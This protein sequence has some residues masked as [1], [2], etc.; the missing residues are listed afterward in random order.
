MSL[1]PDI[2]SFAH[3]LAD[4]AGAIARR[5][6][7]QPYMVDYKSDKSPVTLADHEIETALRE[8][9][10]DRF[11]DAYGILGEESGASHL[12]AEYVWVIDPIDGTRAFIAGKPTFTTLIALCKNGVP[13]LGLID[14]PI[15][16][17][18]WV[19]VQGFPSTRNGQPVTTRPCDDL[20]LAL[21]STTSPE[22]FSAIASPSFHAVRAAARDILYGC[23]GYAYGLLANGG[24]D[25]V[26]E[27]GLKPY[28]YCALAPVISGAG[29]IIT[30][31]RGE[32]LTLHSN[33]DVLA[34]G[35]EALHAIAISMI[36]PPK[37]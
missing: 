14:Q 1:T 10:T 19:G 37:H 20:T 8:A 2:I 33:G 13:V 4:Q 22:Y 30:D 21:I 7:R 35:D 32:S 29:G 27:S 3:T 5:Y 34:C 25:L 6:Y 16:G 36:K 28:D 18:R 31:W 17:D 12:D 15:I 26:I 9:I 11:S 24:V 23:D